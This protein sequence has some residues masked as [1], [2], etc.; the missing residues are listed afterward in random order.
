MAGSL[1]CSPGSTCPSGFRRAPF[2]PTRRQDIQSWAEDRP[3]S[4]PVRSQPGYVPPPFIPPLTVEEQKH[5]EAG[6]QLYS[7]SCAACHQPTGLGQGSLAPPLAD[8][9]W[10]L[11]PESRLARIVLQ[12]VEGPIHADGVGFDSAMPS[13]AS[14]NDDQLAGILT[15]IRR[16]WEN[17]AS[18]VAPATITSIRAS[19]SKRGRAWTEK[20]L[21][22]IQ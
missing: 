11:G 3:P 13:W 2:S 19:T 15:Y 22:E 18:P 10:V 1:R 16:S 20:E 14:F 12:G 8:S 6:Q 4:P 9:E 7:G 17:S 5:F 21:S